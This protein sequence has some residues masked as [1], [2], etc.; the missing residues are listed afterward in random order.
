MGLGVVGLGLVAL[1][2]VGSGLWGVGNTIGGRPIEGMGDICA[3]V[4]GA[5]GWDCTPDR[6]REGRERTLDQVVVMTAAVGVELILDW[7]IVG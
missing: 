1:G 5:K 6:W 7:D 4:L 3:P 2:L